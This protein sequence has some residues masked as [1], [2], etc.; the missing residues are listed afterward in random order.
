MRLP[1]GVRGAD[2]GLREVAPGIGR[3]W[4]SA[5]TI[6]AFGEAHPEAAIEVSAPLRL[7]LDSASGFVGAKAAIQQG[8][9]GSGALVGVADTGL[10]VTHPDFLD[11]Q[12][13]TRVAWLL[14]LSVPPRG[15]YPD[16]EKSFG[17][18]DASGN[19][20]AGAVWSAQDIDAAMAK[21]S[22]LPQDEVGHGT[23][24]TACAAGNGVEI[25]RAH[26]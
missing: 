23:L 25:G 6:V 26:V 18:T 3:L 16:L 19:L 2:W 7:L 8:L 9:D 1:A 13:H 20:V 11:S 12:G 14:D 22:V 5:Q 10:D 24:V 21:G 4:G 17:S 15:I